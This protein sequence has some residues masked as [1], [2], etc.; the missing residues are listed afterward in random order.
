MRAPRVPRALLVLTLAVLVHNIAWV[1]AFPAWQGPDEYAHYAYLERLAS[2]HR[3][4]PL[5]DRNPGPGLSPA[6][7]GSMQSTGFNELRFRLPVRPFGSVGSDAVRFPR[8]SDDL[9]QHNTGQLGANSYPPAYYVAALPLFEL[10]GLSNATERNYSIRLLSALLG[11]LIVPLTFRLGRVVALSVPAA[12]VAAGLAT[13]APIMT[14]Q[15]AVFSPDVLLVVAITG[16]AAA[17]LRARDRLDRRAIA[18]V[19]GWAALAALTKPIGLPA[20][21]AVAVPIAILT[22]GRVRRRVRIALLAGASLIGVALGSVFASTLFGIAVPASYSWL[23]RLKF[24]G[25]YL[26]QYYL[27]RPSGMPV[28]LPPATPASPPAA[29]MWGKEGVGILGWLTTMLPNWAYRLA[30]TPTLVAGGLAFAGGLVGV[31]RDRTRRSG[32]LALVLASLAYILV[33]HASEAVVMLT[34]GNRLLQG[35]YFLPVYPLIAVAII[36]GLSRLSERIAISVGL[37]VWAAWTVVAL[38]ALNTVVVY[39][40]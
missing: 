31:A 7:L 18:Y 8:E 40:G 36:A 6:M 34:N 4:M 23:E 13:S 9:K 22:F 14:Q 28:V 30:W 26:W 5:D 32:V 17:T 3:L 27:P 21:V 37:V 25:E 1:V 15:S 19:L 38:D 24:S 10:P 29:W 20:A 2:D 11:A 16:L 35:R 39:F 12:L 33:L